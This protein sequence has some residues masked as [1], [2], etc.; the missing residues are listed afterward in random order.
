MADD[1]RTF[2]RLE[3][4]HVA[5]AAFWGSAMLIVALTKW[6]EGPRVVASL[7]AWGIDGVILVYLT[8]PA[9]SVVV[10]P[11]HVTVRNPYLEYTV[12][13]RLIEGVDTGTY[14]T[15]RLQ[16]HGTPRGIRL[17]ALNLNLPR[18][19]PSSPGRHERNAVIRMVAEIPEETNGGDVCRR[20][21]WPNLTLAGFGILTAITAWTYLLT[22]QS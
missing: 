9:A 12:P 19:Y 13:R 18:G 16:V 22:I 8:A 14:W 10:T 5:L 20:V 3:P 21:R 17:A 7:L 2:R 6:S 11:R 15:P 1:Q 4:L